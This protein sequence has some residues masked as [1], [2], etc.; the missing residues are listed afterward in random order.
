MKL[1]LVQRVLNTRE[2]IFWGLT[3]LL[4]NVHNIIICKVWPKLPLLSF[5]SIR[6]LYFKTSNMKGGRWFGFL[7]GMLRLCFA[8]YFIATHGPPH[9]LLSCMLFLSCCPCWEITGMSHL[10]ERVILN[11]IPLR[12]S[13]SCFHSV[14]PDPARFL[15]PPFFLIL[16]TSFMDILHA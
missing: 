10:P 6:W 15:L 14:L 1:F 2:H 16:C 9:P 3:I 12:P 4:E 11:R 13:W 7:Q 5:L 8:F